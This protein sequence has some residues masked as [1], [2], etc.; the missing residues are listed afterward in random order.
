M[1]LI[2]RHY[3]KVLLCTCLVLLIALLLVVGKEHLDSVEPGVRPEQSSE[4]ASP[5]SA[6]VIFPLNKDVAD[7]PLS[8]E[9]PVVINGYTWNGEMP[10]FR[11]DAPWHPTLASRLHLDN[12]PRH[13]HEGVYFN[14]REAFIEFAARYKDK[15]RTWVNVAVERKYKSESLARFFRNM[16]FRDLSENLEYLAE[17][18]PGLTEKQYIVLNIMNL[19]HGNYKF[20]TVVA[21]PNDPLDFIRNELADCS[22]LSNLM[23]ILLELQGIRSKSVG[24]VWNFP[25]CSYDGKTI[26]GPFFSSHRLVWAENIIVDAETNLAFHIG[27]DY[28]MASLAPRDRLMWL[29]DNNRVY[30][31]YNWFIKPDVREEQLARNQDGGLIAF[32]YYYYF[33]GTTHKGFYLLPYSLTGRFISKQGYFT[34]TG[35]LDEKVNAPSLSMTSGK[36]GA[37]RDLYSEWRALLQEMLANEGKDPDEYDTSNQVSALLSS[38][39]DFKRLLNTHTVNLVE[40]A[41]LRK[42][43]LRLIGYLYS[44]RGVFEGEVLGWGRSTPFDAFSDGTVNPPYTK[45]TFQSYVCLGAIYEAI[46]CISSDEDLTQEERKRVSDYLAKANRILDSWDKAYVRI[47]EEGAE[48]RAYYWYSEY[49]RD[50]MPV[51]NV[52][53]GMAHVWLQRYW[54][55]KEKK[56]ARKAVSLSRFLVYSIE[57]DSWDESCVIWPYSPGRGSLIADSAH[58]RIEARLLMEIYKANLISNYLMK[59]IINTYKRT[60]TDDP[61]V[62][63]MYLDGTRGPISRDSWEGG[64]SI[65]RM[66]TVV[67]DP[68]MRALYENHIRESLRLCKAKKMSK[69]KLRLRMAYLAKAMGL[70]FRQK[71]EKH[72]PEQSLG[73][74]NRCEGR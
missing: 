57:T 58:S 14:S 30:G 48:E 4:K 62:F 20:G 44:L 23:A 32:Y 16:L 3:K 31:F 11:H 17:R 70:L 68:K 55:T 53:G 73:A 54:I 36:D 45:Y 9:E 42:N 7:A 13:L 37:Y 22:E 69:P 33:Y 46:S 18:Y 24:Y 26:L 35:A 1:H 63:N 15:L 50:A 51:A 60:M 40:N 52:L 19:V 74:S 8:K 64:L 49:S 41:S 71:M 72:V 67:D 59:R 34:L 65:G 66:L 27:K 56:A 43:M 29:L 39:C 5:T 61:L 6:K 10:P 47:L 21:N 25:S 12:V 38:C 2:A 28:L